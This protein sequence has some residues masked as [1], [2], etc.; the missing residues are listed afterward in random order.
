[1]DGHSTCS[2]K[3]RGARELL[4]DTAPFVVLQ[5]ALRFTKIGP[6]ERGRVGGE[7]GVIV[8]GGWASVVD[9]PEINQFCLVSLLC[10]LAVVTRALNTHLR[11]TV[12][13]WH[14]Q[15][16]FILEIVSIRSI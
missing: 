16:L 11:K 5:N 10:E 1:M 12:E 4:I 14:G 2:A 13:C 7:V 3:E 6:P 8:R 15:I 9:A